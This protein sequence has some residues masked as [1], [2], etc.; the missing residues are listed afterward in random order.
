MFFQEP[1]LAGI[2]GQASTRQQYPC[3]HIAQEVFRSHRVALIPTPLRAAPS[4]Q[5]A[6]AMQGTRVPLVGHACSALQENTNLSQDL[7]HALIVS[8]TLFPLLW[9][10][11][12]CQHASRAR[13]A[14]NLLWGA[15][16]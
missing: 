14:L 1:T 5:T 2:A 7:Q 13:Q 16:H 11:H 4:F 12:R 9:Q 10:Q 8:V 6:R 15:G 3:Q